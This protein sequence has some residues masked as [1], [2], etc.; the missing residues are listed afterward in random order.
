MWLTENNAILT[1]DNLIID[2]RW[3]LRLATSVM[4]M[5]Q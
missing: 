1:N 4:R 5:N 2:T 3:G